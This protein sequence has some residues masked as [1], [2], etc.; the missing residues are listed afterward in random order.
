MDND[1]RT[2]DDVYREN[3]IDKRFSKIRRIRVL[4]G[5]IGMNPEEALRFAYEKFRGV[6][7]PIS[8]DAP[9]ILVRLMEDICDERPCRRKLILENN[10]KANS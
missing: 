2:P 4:A 8:E 1:S 10:L 7:Y 9:E 3:G 5:E 6:Y